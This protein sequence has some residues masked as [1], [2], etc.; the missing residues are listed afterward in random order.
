MR[1][2]SRQYDEVKATYQSK[3]MDNWSTHI[4]DALRYLAVNYRRLYDMPAAP[5]TYEYKSPT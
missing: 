2:Y 4:V 1:E 3:P 5:R